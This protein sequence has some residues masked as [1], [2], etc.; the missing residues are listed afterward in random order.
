MPKVGEYYYVSIVM[1]DKSSVTL[2]KIVSIDGTVVVL[3]SGCFIYGMKSV[4]YTE[5]QYFKKWEPNWF[6]KMLGYK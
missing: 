6:W 5:L 3:E 4:D 2:E 1:G